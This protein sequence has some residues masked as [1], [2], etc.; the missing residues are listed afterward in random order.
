MKIFLRRHAPTPGNLLGNYVG[1]TDEALGPEGVELAHKTGQDSSVAVVHTSGLQRTIQTAAILY[2][3]AR[4]I[5]HTDLNE[6]N[7]GVFEGKN[8][9][10]MAEDAGYAAWVASQCRLPCPGGEGRDGFSARCCR[11]FTG[12]VADAREKGLESLHFVVHGGTI[13]AILHGFVV[14][15]RGYFDR[16]VGY[17]ELFAVEPAQLE[18]KYMFADNPVV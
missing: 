13:Q 7:F 15:Q 12:I 8:W 5:H 3:Q 1:A 6:M 2:P 11:A 4:L 14:P 10:G 17:C 9:R 16:R 18:G